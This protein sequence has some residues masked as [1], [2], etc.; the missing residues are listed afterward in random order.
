[1]ANTSTFA[2][3]EA[4]LQNGWLDLTIPELADSLQ[5]LEEKGLIT[6]AEKEAL[7]ELA[8]KLRGSEQPDERGPDLGSSFPSSSV[9]PFSS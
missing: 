2:A 9:S 6:T 3:L 4:M 8:R 1:M 7:L 5:F